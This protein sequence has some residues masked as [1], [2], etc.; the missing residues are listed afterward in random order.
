[1]GVPEQGWVVAIAAAMQES[2]LRNVYDG[3]RDSVGLFQQRPSVGWGT[4]QQVATSTYTETKFFEHLTA[5]PN[6]QK[7]SLD[8]A[9]QTVPGSGFPTVYAQHRHHPR[10]TRLPLSRQVVALVRTGIRRTAPP[11]VGRHAK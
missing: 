11:G 6:C 4:P 7:M 9:A 1:M 5:T 2:S 8:D 10:G 3:D